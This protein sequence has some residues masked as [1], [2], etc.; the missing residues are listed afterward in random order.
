MV[1]SQR[2]KL[3]SSPRPQPDLPPRP[4]AWSAR[5]LAVP[6]LLLLCA[7]PALAG[8][9]AKADLGE[10]SASEDLALLQVEGGETTLWTIGGLECRRN[11][12]PVVDTAMYFE[13]GDHYAYQASQSDLYLTIHY[14]DVGKGSLTL[15]YDSLNGGKYAVANNFLEA[16]DSVE[17]TDSKR[18]KA[19][20]FR[21]RD[22]YFGNR[23]KEGTDFRIVKTGG[24]FFYVDMAYLRVFCNGRAECTRMHPS[25]QAGGTGAQ[26]RSL[27][28]NPTQ[29]TTARARM[30]VLGTYDGGG[31]FRDVSDAEVQSWMSLMNQWGLMLALE[32][33]A[34]TSW[35]CDGEQVFNTLRDNWDHV[36]DNGG[37][38]DIL[39]VDEPLRN[40]MLAKCWGTGVNNNYWP[41]IAEVVRWHELVRA[42]Y[43]NT[44]I[45]HIMPYRYHTKTTIQNWIRDLNDALVAAGLPI[46]DAF[47]LDPDWRVFPGDGNW[48]EVQQIGYHF[49]SQNMP[50]SMIYNPPRAG[51]SGSTNNYDFW[52]DI[53]DQAAAYYGA[54]GRAD[55]YDV[56][57]WLDHLP[58]T[59]PETQSY[60]MTDTFN[61]FVAQYLN[62]NDA[63]FVS[64]TIPSSMTA[65]QRVTVNV[66]MRNNGT[67][68]WYR[69]G[70]LS[71][72]LSGLQ[73]VGLFG[74]T[75]H[76]LNVGETVAP[77]QTRT[78]TF[79]MTARAAPGTYSVFWRMQDEYGEWFGESLLK[80]VNVAAAS[81]E[82]SVIF[83]N[84]DVIDGLRRYE[85]EPGNAETLITS[86]GGR[87]CRRTKHSN[88]RHIFMLV[89][90][91]F[92]YQGSRPVVDVTIEYFDKGWDG[93]K[94]IYDATGGDRNAG[95]VNLTNTWTWKTKTWHLTDAY[96]GN[97]STSY[98]IDFRLTSKT[99]GKR[100]YIYRIEVSE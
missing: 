37:Q 100:F 85:P 73:D 86:I 49:S 96:F 7:S 26:I 57:S 22:A 46:I 30:D 3:T 11:L 60:T 34:V 52:D 99:A 10:K 77:G 35:S 39:T 91:S 78:F 65:G 38:V 75:S 42:S 50:F 48:N 83:G 58:T 89:D 45:Y 28:E 23:Q 74:A 16:P 29:W 98:G 67:A 69:N 56:Q 41:A 43:P 62:D 72:K 4:R 92:A 24:D 81:S 20:T 31:G 8:Y 17:L 90:D 44:Q 94:L 51:F 15:E 97:R 87:T 82:V 84:P 93:I 66:S 55:E 2:P 19:K 6:L 32:T 27:F 61:D 59:V 47:S 80:T 21:L 79:D 54:A 68:T 12:N 14:F 13:V 71:Y 25:P 40:A 53:M 88:D 1:D 36:I 76:W 9:M 5:T 70:S 18:W 33:G 64:S 63:D 95:L